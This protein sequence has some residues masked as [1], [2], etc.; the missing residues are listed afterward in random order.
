MVTLFI[1]DIKWKQ[2][3]YPSID[4][5]ISNMW[6]ICTVEYYSAVKERSTDIHYN[7]DES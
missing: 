4:E 5:A 3:K 1:V 2:P 7:K 6:Y